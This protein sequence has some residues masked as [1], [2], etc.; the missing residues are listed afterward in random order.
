M[1][2]NEN[3]F[4]N[5]IVTESLLRLI[6]DGGVIKTPGHEEPCLCKANLKKLYSN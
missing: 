1:N 3:N 5:K 4:C 2:S 6:G